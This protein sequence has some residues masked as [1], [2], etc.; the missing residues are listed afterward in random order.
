MCHFKVPS[1]DSVAGV[2]SRRA[3]A[4][5]LTAWAGAASHRPQQAGV[6]CEDF[7]LCMKGETVKINHRLYILSRERYDGWRS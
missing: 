3:E 2:L 5:G 1:E 6:R 4:E 7:M